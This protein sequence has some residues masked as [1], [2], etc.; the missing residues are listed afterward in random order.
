MSRFVHHVYTHESSTR[1]RS[2]TISS[3]LSTSCIRLYVQLCQLTWRLSVNVFLKSVPIRVLVC[4]S[5]GSVC[6][7]VGIPV[8]ELTSEH[9]VSQTTGL[10]IMMFTLVMGSILGPQ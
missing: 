3:A 1:Q 10:Q 8:K 7:C 6:V 5:R 2:T 9:F 4:K